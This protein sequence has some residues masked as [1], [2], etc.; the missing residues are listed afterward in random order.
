MKYLLIIFISLFIFS[1]STTMTYTQEQAEALT[2]MERCFGIKTGM[3]YRNLEQIDDAGY[4]RL[5]KSLRK[6]NPEPL[7][8]VQEICGSKYQMT[9][10][11]RRLEEAKEIFAMR[12]ERRQA[13]GAALL[14]L[15]SQMNEM[16][17]QNDITEPSTGLGTKVCLYNVVGTVHAFNS[18]GI[19]PLTMEFGGV[20][21]FLKN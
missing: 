5:V 2:E 13:I 18:G 3:D 14:V 15:S 11:N 10:T 17:R 20:T 21:G 16:N 4:E 9:L 6:S 12:E 1:C 19:C 7:N 8:L